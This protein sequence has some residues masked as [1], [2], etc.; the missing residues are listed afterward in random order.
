MK[1]NLEGTDRPGKGFF[2]LAR[3]L[4]RDIFDKEALW[5]EELNRVYK[6]WEFHPKQLRLIK[7]KPR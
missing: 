2:N 1:S 4:G 3:E 6:D 7:R 5:I